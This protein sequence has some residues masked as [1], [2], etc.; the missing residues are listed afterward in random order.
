MRIVGVHWRRLTEG[1]EIGG[2]IEGGIAGE[3]ELLLMPPVGVIG[4]VEVIIV[5]L[6]QRRFSPIETGEGHSGDCLGSLK[7]AGSQSQASLRWLTVGGV[8]LCWVKKPEVSDHEKQ[9]SEGSW[10]FRW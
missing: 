1:L 10:L 3:V 8:T 6:W 7:R 9:K 5:S 2:L 4:H